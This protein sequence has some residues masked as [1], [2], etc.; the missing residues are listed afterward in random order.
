[1]KSLDMDETWELNAMDVP[2]QL[3]VHKQELA[4][5]LTMLQNQ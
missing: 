4:D 3:I 2:Y 5:V 1:M